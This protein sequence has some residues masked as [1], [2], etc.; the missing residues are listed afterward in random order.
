MTTNFTVIDA[1]FQSRMT[2]LDLLEERG[3]DVER[4]R[5]FTPAEAALAV[6]SSGEAPSHFAGLSFKA[7]KKSDDKTVCDV[8]YASLSRQKLDTF[9]NNISDE[10]APHTEV[11]VMMVEPLADSH[12]A[13]ALKQYIKPKESGERRKLRVSFFYLYAIVINP[14]KH[15]LVP[16]HEI[17]PEAEHKALMDSMYI[18]S[19]TK[20][21][22]IKFHVDPITRCIGAVPGDIIKITRPSASSGESIIYRVCIA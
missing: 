14:L 17:V 21:P 4:Y 2:L 1:I 3:Y 9:F 10:D 11:I 6:T 15:V 13:A 18:V 22:E 12:H 19:K 7:T 16:K 5:N 8:R 20:F